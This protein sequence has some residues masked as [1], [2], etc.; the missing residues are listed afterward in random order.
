M[1]AGPLSGF[2]YLRRR[3]TCGQ[4]WLIA[5]VQLYPFGLLSGLDVSDS[6]SYI[7]EDMLKSLKLSLDI[8]C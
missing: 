1:P 5:E 3:V 6:D 8:Y 2:R 4:A 7:I